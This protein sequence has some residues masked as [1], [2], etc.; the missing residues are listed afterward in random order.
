M[1][2]FFAVPFCC[3][4]ENVTWYQCFLSIIWD[5]KRCYQVLKPFCY[6]GVEVTFSTPEMGENL[7]RQA[8]HGMPVPGNRESH[9]V[10][11]FSLQNP[12]PKEALPGVETFLLQGCASRFLRARKPLIL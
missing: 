10:S 6:K 7:V 8:P 2:C 11:V 12:G 4:L 5:Q 3:F 1:L 9:L